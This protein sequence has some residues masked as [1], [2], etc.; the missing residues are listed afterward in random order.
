MPERGNMCHLSQATRPAEWMSSSK[1]RDP[2]WPHIHIGSFMQCHTFVV[3]ARC[4]I[5]LSVCNVPSI[6]FFWLQ[7]LISTM[8][9]LSGRNEFV[10]FPPVA[11]QPSGSF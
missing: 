7:F 5:V 10:K 2:S 3:L 6:S 8:G 1:D 4:D 11:L 9:S